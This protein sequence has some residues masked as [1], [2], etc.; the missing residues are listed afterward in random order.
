VTSCWKKINTSTSF[1][2]NA[3]CP[4][5]KVE[6]SF[7]GPPGLQIAV[8]I[9]LSSLIVESVRDLVTDHHAD[10]AVIQGAREL[11]V[12]ERRLKDASR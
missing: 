2:Y 5:L 1:T 4:R 7:F 6:H 3:L 9:K 11:R 10:A 8:D 12:I